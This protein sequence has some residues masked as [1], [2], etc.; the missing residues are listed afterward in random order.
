MNESMKKYIWKKVDAA[1]T[2]YTEKFGEDFMKRWT[3]TDYNVNITFTKIKSYNNII[4]GDM[5]VATVKLNNEILCYCYMYTDL[6]WEGDMSTEKK[7]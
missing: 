6:N 5:I 7:H 3:T 2:R 4:V 1:I